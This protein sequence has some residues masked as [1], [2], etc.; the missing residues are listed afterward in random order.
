M[1]KLAL[2]LSTV[3]RIGAAL[4]AVAA[5]AALKIL[6]GQDWS[7]AAV[8]TP[9]P[10]SEL[11]VRSEP[12][13][14]P[15]PDNSSSEHRAPLK[16]EWVA[17]PDDE[18]ADEGPE[19]GEGTAERAAPADAQKASPAVTDLPGGS[20]GSGAASEPPPPDSGSQ[21]PE[22]ETQPE[23][24]CRYPN[25]ALVVKSSRDTVLS[26]IPLA[27][28]TWLGS[29]L[30]SVIVAMDADTHIPA[31]VEAWNL[32]PDADWYVMVD[33]AAYVHL[34][35][36]SSRLLTSQLDPEAAHFFGSIGNFTGCSHELGGKV[37][38]FGA[39]ARGD[40]G[41]ILSRGAVKR[42]VVNADTCMKEL[43]NCLAGDVRTSIC[44]AMSGVNPQELTGLGVGSLGAGQP[45]LKWPASSPCDPVIAVR[46]VSEA[47]VRQL[48]A[49]SDSLPPGLELP[50]AG[51][52]DI[53]SDPPA[54]DLVAKEEGTL[55]MGAVR[56]AS[57]VGHV[58]V[59]A[60]GE[61][62]ALK[63]S[64]GGT[65]TVPATNVLKDPKWIGARAALACHAACVAEARCVSWTLAAG[66]GPRN[67]SLLSG[68]PPPS[69]ENERLKKAW[70]KDGWPWTG[71]IDGAMARWK[72]N[73]SKCPRA[74]AYPAVVANGRPVATADDDFL[75][76]LQAAETA[77]EAEEEG[78]SK[79]Q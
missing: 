49:V 52:F 4:L 17:M 44:L 55:R 76:A 29:S 79:G 50:F 40:A 10:A 6:A 18:E 26:R 75:V 73:G 14:S 1:A 56:W 70:S 72:D 41:I 47:G 64:S 42:M 57:E 25:L 7:P 54:K 2:K 36:L 60:D 77:P 8:D 22:A 62:K 33:D 13:A 28:A 24:A 78:A 48:Q 11:N 46:N 51:I 67:C 66:N 21:G 74:D 19:K 68:I 30:C 43:A 15:K 71:A 27:Q 69:K 58:S 39:Y 31:F 9:P 12:A 35:T 63:F 5:V 20:D 65:G 59:K 23:E 34:P 53:L 3:V 32:W 45:K 61:P 38:D 16:V 37:V